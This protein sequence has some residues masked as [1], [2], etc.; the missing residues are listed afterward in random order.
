MPMMRKTES[1]FGWTMPSRDAIRRAEQALNPSEQGVRDEIGF[2]YIHDA[3]SNRFFPGT[4]VLQTRLRYAL[5]VPWIYQKLFNRGVKRDVE[6]ELAREELTLVSRLSR[7]ETKGVIGR[8]IF[9]RP[10]KQPSTFIYWSA[11]ASW[12]ILRDDGGTTPSRTFVHRMLE[13]A[14]TVKRRTTE[15]YETDESYDPFWP[16][17]EPPTDWDDPDAALN[18]VLRRDEREFIRQKISNVQKPG[19]NQA[20]LLAS[21]VDARAQP[22]W[23]YSTEVAAHADLEDR[24]ALR[25]ARSGA[26]LGAVGRAVYA[27]LLEEV[28]ESRDHRNG[29]GTVHR[30]R[31]LNLIMPQF[32]NDALRTDLENLRAD[33][34]KMPDELFRVLEE[35]CRW[36]RYPQ[37]PVNSLLDAYACAE[38]S[39]KRD[40]ARLPS[41]GLARDRRN[42]WYPNQTTPAEPL[43]FRWHIAQQFLI[44]LNDTRKQKS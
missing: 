23:M 26:A 16:V 7:L 36:L 20:S 30:D 40:R 19:T 33:V 2:L 35:T 3:Y 1:F 13:R 38:Y 25:R 24:P 31:L 6:R 11:L 21:L 32:R 37:T 43:H 42:E 28:C 8:T 44:D 27:A 5:F 29:I 15:E 12:G 41:T 18:F 14:N 39:R 4:S 34:P 17:P 22:T 9:P 10:T